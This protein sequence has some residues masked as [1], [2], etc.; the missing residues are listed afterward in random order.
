MPQDYVTIHCK[1]F[2]DLN[3]SARGNNSRQA[4]QSFLSLHEMKKHCFIY[5]RLYNG[6]QQTS[7]NNCI[8]DEPGRTIPRI[9]AANTNAV[10]QL[11]GKYTQSGGT[12]R[13]V[14]LVRGRVSPRREYPHQ[15][16][17][18]TGG[19]K[20]CRSIVSTSYRLARSRQ[21]NR[22]IQ[23]VVMVCSLLFRSEQQHHNRLEKVLRTSIFGEI[24]R[25]L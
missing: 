22:I 18:I 3:V 16:N 9:S 6:G 1:G 5:L 4:K 25:K 21:A 14:I 8:P 23:V 19:L 17:W 11:G 12:N 24:H 7:W 20:N 2:L 13:L 10:F 15:A